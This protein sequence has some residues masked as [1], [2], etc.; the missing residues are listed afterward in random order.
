[1]NG[2]GRGTVIDRE[3]LMTWARSQG[4]RV[5]VACEDWESI[6]Y[7]TLARQ[8]DG[9]S[10]IQRHRWVLPE[11]I[12]RRRL[13]MT[14]VVGLSH[15]VDGAECNHVRRI[16]PPVLS[17]ADEAARH[18]VALVA[19]AMVEVERRAV[20]GATVDNLRV[21]TVERAVHWRPF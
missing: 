21:Y 6:T 1:M 18:D 11:P 4:V 2:D 16:V 7:E 19:A 12:T 17:S 13:L 8:P 9:T 3:T 15:E 20:C 5:R 14:Y 10:L